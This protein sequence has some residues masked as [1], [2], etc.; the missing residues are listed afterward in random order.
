MFT[1]VSKVQIP[2]PF[3]SSLKNSNHSTNTVSALTAL[4]LYFAQNSCIAFL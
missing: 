1:R 2:V 3:Y 4:M